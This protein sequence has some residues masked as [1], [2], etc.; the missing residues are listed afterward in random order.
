MCRD[1]AYTDL[2]CN[3]A[4]LGCGALDAPEFGQGTCVS[5]AHGDTCQQTCIYGIASGSDARVCTDGVYT[6]LV[7]VDPQACADLAAPQYGT[8]ACVSV[9]EGQECVQACDWGVL[10]GLATRRCVDGAFT[11]SPL[12]CRAPLDC[13][14]LAEPAFGTGACG[15]T[16]HDS[17]C[18]QACAWGVVSGDVQRSCS[19]GSYS[20]LVCR[21]PEPC[22]GLEAPEHGSSGSCDPSTST[23]HGGSCEHNC[24]WGVSAG[25]ETRACTAGSY[26]VLECLAP[27]NCGLV[28]A[29]EHGTGACSAT[30][31]GQACEQSCDWGIASGSTSR[32][33]TNGSYSP[34]TCRSPLDC[35]ALPAPAYGTGSCEAGTA[36]TQTCTQACL[37]DVSSG[38]NTRTCTDGLYSDLTCR[39]PRVCAPLAAP[40]YG[41]G[42]CQTVQSGSACVQSCSFGAKTGSTKRQCSDGSYTP[43]ECVPMLVQ[44][45]GPRTV[46]RC[47]SISATASVVRSSDMQGSPVTYQWVLAGSTAPA[48][49]QQAI[50]DALSVGTLGQ[51]PSVML[52]NA[53]LDPGSTYTLS[54]LVQ[55]VR[56]AQVS[57]QAVFELS[58]AP[59]PVLTQPDGT[60]QLALPHQPYSFLAAAGQ[61]PCLVSTSST[62]YITYQWRQLSGPTVSIATPTGLRLQFPSGALLP[63]TTYE[64]ELSASSSGMYNVSAL[65]RVVVPASDLIADIKGGDVLH[66]IADPT[67]SLSVDASNSND[68]DGHPITFEW[69]CRLALSEQACFEPLSE[70][71]NALANAGPVLSLS[72]SLLAPTAPGDAYIFAA[73]VFSTLPQREATVSARVVV[74]ESLVLEVEAERVTAVAASPL[75]AQNKLT[76]T[77]LQPR[78]D[79]AI[80]WR[81]ESGGDGTLDLDGIR[82]SASNLASLVIKPYALTPGEVYVFAVDVQAPT[83]VEGVVLTGSDTVRVRVNTAPHSGSCS[84]TPAANGTVNTLFEFDCDGF[85]DDTSDLPLS[86]SFELRT[87][88]AWVEVGAAQS[89]GQRQ[90]KLPAGPQANGRMQTV[91]AVVSDRFGGRVT[92]ESTIEV[93]PPATPEATQVYVEEQVSRA[94]VEALVNT[95]TSA[96]AQ[97]VLSLAA[98]VEPGS[99][100]AEDLADDLLGGLT[101]LAD[102]VETSAAS[103]L[104]AVQMGESIASILDVSGGESET[105]YADS[106]ALLLFMVEQASSAL[107]LTDVDFSELG[108]SLLSVF[109]QVNEAVA[110]V[111]AAVTATERLLYPPA[112][113]ADGANRRRLLTEFRDFNVSGPS[114]GGE[115]GEALLGAASTISAGMLQ[116]A[117]VGED[118]SSVEA[119]G[120]RLSIQR[121]D[122]TQG[123]TITSSG[124]DTTN[125]QVPSSV[126]ARLGSQAG[127]VLLVADDNPFST[128]ENPSLSKLVTVTLTD[129]QSSEELTVEGLSD[130]I[131]IRIPVAIGT[132]LTESACMYW[133][134]QLL[135][136]SNDGCEA[137]VPELTAAELA[138]AP[139]IDCYC[140][141]LTSF[142][143]FDGA[144][145]ALGQIELLTLDDILNLTW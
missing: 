59:L 35:P 25:A 106:Q 86:Y 13:P 72:N 99:A 108:A 103:V 138:N 119:E 109:G 82:S 84:V 66:S 51:Q 18:L 93:R 90:L 110:S 61:S 70:P 63:A 55:D 30:V 74:V 65:L 8:G 21:A 100:A 122:L 125:A 143:V 6:D 31:H 136:W 139:Y 118:T 46:S 20:A 80:Q 27:I 144:A 85:E 79:W 42:A 97:S 15:N 114:D 40:V 73:S 95:D 33:C 68:P 7:C 47:T 58:V 60:T 38:N 91:R 5:T 48:S 88:N 89:S 11:G 3:P 12:M 39:A 126:A 54:V 1:G 96:F 29:P 134:T 107:N 128:A 124:N 2:T 23:P 14:A 137:V 36:H 75:N 130:P 112:A 131:R 133:D 115:W 117:V 9:P 98:V 105:P 101:A 41:N 50:R 32:L 10:S 24:T 34:L 77:V 113:D 76:L 4:P 45:A 145:N 102:Q 121:V 62:S 37:W 26:S 129:A 17:A 111:N 16:A 78:P 28:P 49:R 57:A 22:N 69:A 56:G 104:Q 43:L 71:A 83:E 52:D 81:L 142:A 64:F 141:H 53:L 140:D 67:L 94:L 19:D 44:V 120:I 116:G 127:L 135:V 132:N 87:A 123:P 92:L